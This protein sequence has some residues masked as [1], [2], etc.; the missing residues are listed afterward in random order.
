LT[1]NDA[2]QRLVRFLATVEAADI[3]ASVDRI[4]PNRRLNPSIAYANPITRRFAQSLM[5]PKA[6]HFDLSD[7]LPPAFGARPDQ[8]MAKILKDYLRGTSNIEAVTRKLQASA[9]VT[10]DQRPGK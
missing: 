5:E 10:G 6:A 7:L 8:G 1:S 9:R 4:S 3:W 2:A